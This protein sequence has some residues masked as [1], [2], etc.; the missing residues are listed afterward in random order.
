MLMAVRLR[1]SM[2]L[3]LDKSAKDKNKSRNE[4]QCGQHDERVEKSEDRSEY[5]ER[6]DGN[7]INQVTTGSTVLRQEKRT[8]T[9]GPMGAL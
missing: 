5:K 1:T 4:L 8:E 3:G 7:W 2:R 9:E 6:K